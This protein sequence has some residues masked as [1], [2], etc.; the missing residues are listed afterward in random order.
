MNKLFSKIATLSVG[1]AMAIG[2]GVAVGSKETRVAK[3]DT[4]VTFTVGTDS[5]DTSLSKNG[6][7][8]IT[9]SGV[10]NRTD[11]YRIYA[12]NSMTVS[13]SS[14]NITAMSFTISQ[15]TFT[16]DVGTWSNG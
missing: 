10:F 2:V 14:G 9:T 8:V 6:V 1:L 16:A 3:A 5:G 15:N 7:S 4:T 11:N 12:N 13:C